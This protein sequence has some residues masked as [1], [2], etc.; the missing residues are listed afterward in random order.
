MPE[1][2]GPGRFFAVVGPSGAG[3]DSLLA[4]A[5]TVLGGDGRFQFVR[6]TVT[7][8]ADAASEDHDTMTPEA[9]AVAKA[10]GLFSVTWD[11]HG[12]S[13]GLPVS[14]LDHVREGGFAIANCSRAALPAVCAAFPKV[15]I[16][17]VTVDPAVLAR[18]LEARGRESPAEVKGR[19]ARRV[20]AYPAIA[21]VTQIDNSGDLSDASRSF[22]DAIL[23]RAG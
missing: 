19:L 1:G 18:R 2:S 17:S 8:P 10:A 9:F 16:L 4:A 15:H 5:R 14:V 3:K 23:E 21:E 12:L 22:L 11:A 7:R 6:R 20:D 13:Y